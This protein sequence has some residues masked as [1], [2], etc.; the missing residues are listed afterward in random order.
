MDNRCIYAC[1][2]HTADDGGLSASRGGCDGKLPG[3]APKCYS[4]SN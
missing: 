1:P 2:D 3:I 4:I